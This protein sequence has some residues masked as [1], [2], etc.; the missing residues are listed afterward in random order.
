M[1]EGE[2]TTQKKI[3]LLEMAET[4][5]TSVSTVHKAL[6]GKKGVSVALRDRIVSFAHTQGYQVDA[7]KRNKLVNIVALFPEPVGFDR[8]FYQY[9][10]EGLNVRS[11]ELP[12]THI[13]LTTLTFDGTIEDQLRVLSS[14]LLD[15]STTVD[16]LV[17]IVWSAERL[18][19][20]LKKL[21]EAGIQIYTVSA[22]AP[23]HLRVANIA[24]NSY[25]LG[26]VAADY[27][28]ATI[29]ESGRVILIGTRRDSKNHAQV[30]RGF[31]DRLSKVRP[32]LQ[33]IELYES[34]GYPQ[35]LFETMREFLE[36][37]DDIKGIYANNART[38][39]GLYEASLAHPFPNNLRIVGSEIFT[40][41]VAA[42]NQGVIH[43]LIDQNPFAHGYQALSLVYDN[44]VLGKEIRSMNEIPIHIY[45]PS[46]LPKVKDHS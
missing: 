15:Q 31:Y 41:S 38:T 1:S 30:V 21:Q 16:G 13:K 11:R 22:D 8:Y 18:F 29:H 26:R 33:I 10:W 12:K 24:T 27:L 44:L 6:Y 32:E 45:L 28:G 3:T 39:A 9:I 5:N 34:V 36:T 23:L 19:D 40:Q 20:A 46:N 17:T 42:V 7:R 35:S 14:I 43:A 37:F 4:L 2:N 25:T